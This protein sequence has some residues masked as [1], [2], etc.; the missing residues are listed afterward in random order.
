MCNQRKK[1]ERM[2]GSFLST[3]KAKRKK[4]NIGEILKIIKGIIRKAVGK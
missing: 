1:N 2:E 4:K 3:H